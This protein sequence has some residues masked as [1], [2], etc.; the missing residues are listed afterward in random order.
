MSRRAKRPGHE[1][2]KG[3][4]CM[5][6]THKEI[7]QFFFNEGEDGKGMKKSAALMAEATIKELD[8]GESHPNK[9][10]CI[11]CASEVTAL[12]SQMSTCRKKYAK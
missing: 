7:I 8:S 10:H 1:K 2:T 6:F 11:S 4:E 5:T 12:I 9:K 3:H